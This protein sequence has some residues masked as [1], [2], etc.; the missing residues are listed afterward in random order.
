MHWSDTVDDYYPVNPRP[1]WG[2]GQPAHALR[3]ILER[4]RGVYEAELDVIAEHRAA[5]HAVPHD[6]DPSGLE[7]ME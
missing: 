1:R 4:S 3:A 2:H 6:P 7:P 5:L